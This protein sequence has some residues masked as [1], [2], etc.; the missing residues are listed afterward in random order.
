L[1]DQPDKKKKATKKKSVRKTLFG[2]PKKRTKL[3]KSDAKSVEKAETPKPDPISKR[4]KKT[5]KASDSIPMDDIEIPHEN[6]PPPR[7]LTFQTAT[8][9]KIGNPL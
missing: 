5:K 8:V 1:S 9:T 7:H 4:R 6:T 2:K 3:V